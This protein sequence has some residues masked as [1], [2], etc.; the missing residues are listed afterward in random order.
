MSV[1]EEIVDCTLEYTYVTLRDSRCCLVVNTVR[2][3]SIIFSGE[4]RFYKEKST[5]Y[6]TT[7]TGAILEIALADL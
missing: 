4:T 5:S 1:V 2:L 3:N 6:R 7:R